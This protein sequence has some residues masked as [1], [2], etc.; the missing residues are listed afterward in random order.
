MNIETF[1]QFH[2]PFPPVVSQKIGYT[3]N[4][5]PSLIDMEP[6]FF[7]TDNGKQA[8]SA[9]LVLT[10]GHFLREGLKKLTDGFFAQYFS[11]A[12]NINEKEMK[13]IAKS[14]LK[15]KKLLENPQESID[16]EENIK[17]EVWKNTKT[18]KGKLNAISIK[19]TGEEA[20]FTHLDNEITVTKKTL[21]SLPH[22]IGH[23]VQEHSTNLLKRLQRSRGRYAK[24]ALI[25]YGLGREKPSNGDKQSLWGLAQNL[26][27]KYNVLIPL[28]AFTPELITEFAA[29]KIGIDYIKTYIKNL[30]TN[31]TK[32]AKSIANSEQILKTAKKHYAVA[33]CTYLAL[34]LFAVLDNFIFKKALKN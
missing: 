18:S 25:L 9:V 34:P 20:F 22:E 29:S 4:A 11:K 23:A 13:N 14:M 21:I 5:M 6:D 26:L 3:S 19:S 15:E 30:K 2:N 12:Q 31:A 27:H 24:L 8:T 32:N 10:L 1:N 7:E 17:K 28:I 16:F 33:F